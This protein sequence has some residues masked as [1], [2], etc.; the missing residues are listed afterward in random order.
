MSAAPQYVTLGEVAR[1]RL[2]PMGRTR[3]WELAKSG[4]LPGCIRI[5]RRFY[6][7]VATLLAA[8]EVSR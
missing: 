2:L 4:E 8:G 1:Q 5:G 6:V 3:L 7:N